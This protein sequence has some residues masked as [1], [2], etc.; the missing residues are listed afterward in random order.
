MKEGRRDVKEV[1]VEVPVGAAVG[2]V[3][4]ETVGA[5]V[6]V[7]GIG[8]GYHRRHQRGTAVGISQKGRKEE[9]NNGQRSAAGLTSDKS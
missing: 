1:V 6:G 2:G 4:V 8:N 3:L 9:N 7:V 5:S